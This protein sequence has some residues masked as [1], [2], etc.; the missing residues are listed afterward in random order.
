MRTPVQEKSALCL[1][2]NGARICALLTQVCFLK[3]IS[4]GLKEIHIRELRVHERMDRR[5]I[6]KWVLAVHCIGNQRP[7]ICRKGKAP[8][9]AGPLRS[10]TPANG[11]P[12][13]R[14]SQPQTRQEIRLSKCSCAR[15][16][17]DSV[18]TPKASH[19]HAF[20]IL[21]ECP[22]GHPTGRSGRDE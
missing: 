12:F 4:V 18:L 3:V 22:R 6:S 15:T 16:I 17:I 19:R 2:R 1:E 5:S 11:R 20:D 8:L 14:V 10:T 9:L 21:L 7:K 13:R